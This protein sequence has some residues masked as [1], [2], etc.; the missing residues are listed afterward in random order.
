MIESYW[1]PN[2]KKIGSTMKS[3]SKENVYGPRGER[4]GT[5]SQQGTFDVGGRRVANL[6]LPGLLIARSVRKPRR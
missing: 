3:G 2:G 6:P 1:S 5:T 4:L